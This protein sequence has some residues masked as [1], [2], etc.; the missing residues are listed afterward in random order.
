MNNLG[1]IEK[2]GFRMMRNPFFFSAA[3]YGVKLLTYSI[4]PLEMSS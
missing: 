4:F 1:G 2:N 3:I